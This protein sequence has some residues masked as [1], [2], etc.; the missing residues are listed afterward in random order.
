MRQWIEQG[1]KPVKQELGWADFPVRSDRAIR[2]HGALVGCACCLCWWAAGHPDRDRDRAAH[3]GRRAVG[4]PPS[5][6]L[7][8][9]PGAG[10]KWGP[11]ATGD[12]TDRAH[13]LLTAAVQAA[14]QAAVLAPCAA[15]GAG[16]A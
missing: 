11:V 1:Y 13:R 4:A 5:R 15:A 8:Q 6:S 14:V 12:L 7:A 16:L 3:A 10:K 2:R 9:E